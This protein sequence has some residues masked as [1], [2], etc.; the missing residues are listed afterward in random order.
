MDAVA[1]SVGY[2]DG[3]NGPIVSG[4]AFP[5]RGFTRDAVVRMVEAGILAEDEPLELIDG[6]LVYTSPQGPLHSMLGERLCALLRERYPVGYVVISQR[7]IAC[8]E[9]SQ[10]EPDVA[11][12]R[13][14]IDNFVRE[15]RHPRATEAVLVVEL[16]Y[17]SQAV[18]AGK[19]PVYAAAGVPVYWH[20]DIVGRTLTVHTSPTA[21][22][23]ADSVTLTDGDDASFPGSTGAVAISSLLP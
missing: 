13:G 22:G 23:Y 5:H 3:M 4:S 1:P 8:G 16:S 10:P 21:E 17:T 14:S 2:D 7:L 19:A 9:R 18:D 20:L 6:E 12:I 15:A 11:V